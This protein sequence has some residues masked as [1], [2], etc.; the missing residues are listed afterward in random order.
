M[1]Y[2]SGFAN[3]WVVLGQIDQI[4]TGSNTDPARLGHLDYRTEAGQ[5][6]GSPEEAWVGKGLH[7][8]DRFS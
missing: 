1:A 6:R 3:R 8:L 5:H 2:E 4:R 7:R